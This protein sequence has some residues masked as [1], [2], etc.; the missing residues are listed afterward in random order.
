M[1]KTPFKKY[2]SFG[3]SVVGNLEHFYKQAPLE[4][5]QKLIGL[6]FPEKLTYENTSFRTTKTNEVFSFMTSNIAAFEG[7][8]N[9]KVRI[10]ADQSS[11]APPAGLEP[12]TL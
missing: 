7:Y 3:L 5:K 12:A 11:S 2:L 1:G 10:S 4:V 6:V 8:K 9:K